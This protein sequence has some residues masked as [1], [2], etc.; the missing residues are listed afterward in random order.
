LF[1]FAHPEYFWLL[2]LIPSMALVY[3]WSVYRRRRRL[4][5]FGAA[6]TIAPLMPDAS[7]APHFTQFV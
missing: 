5:R 3:A 7:P 1:R 2:T 4:E 6:A